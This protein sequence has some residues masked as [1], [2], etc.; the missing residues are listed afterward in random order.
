MP[1]ADQGSQ[2]ALWLALLQ[3]GAVGGEMHAP[4]VQLHQVRQAAGA[5]GCSAAAGEEALLMALLLLQPGG[6]LY[7]GGCFPPCRQVLLLNMAD[8]Q[9]LW[10]QE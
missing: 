2:H 7:V 6:A 10:Q 5:G 3:R 9:R 4:H 8:K 1:A